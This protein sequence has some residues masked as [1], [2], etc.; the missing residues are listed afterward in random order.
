MPLTPALENPI[1]DTVRS[2]KKSKRQLYINQVIDDYWLALV[3]REA[4]LQ[5]RREVLSG[6]AK[7]GIFGDG[8]ELPQ[9]AMARAFKKGDYRAGYYRDQTLMMALGLA[10]VGSLFAQMYGDVEGDPYSSGRQM[11][12]HYATPF[13]KMNGD[14]NAQNLQYNI[15]AGISSTGGQMARA[16]GLAFASKK[17]REMNDVEGFEQF[18]NNGNEVCFCT[19]G[20]ASTSEGVFWE[21]VNAAGVEQIPLVI[22][23]WDDGFG[24]SV[25]TEKQTTK[26]SISKI[27]AGFQRNDDGNGLDIYTVNAFDYT[28]LCVTFERAAKKA[29]KKHRP[30]VVHV[31]NCTQPQGHS[32]SGSHERYKSKDRL[33]W[34][35]EYDCI[36]RMEEWMLVNN[37]ISEDQINIMRRESRA[38]VRNSKLEAWNKYQSPNDQVRTQLLSIVSDIDNSTITIDC[39]HLINSLVYPTRSELL[40][41]GRKLS[42]DLHASEKLIP[43]KLQELISKIHSDLQGSYGSYL[44][45]GGAQSPLQVPIVHPIY[46][47]KSQTINGYQVINS[48]F[49]NMLETRRDLFVFGEDVGKIGDVN[50]GLAGLQ[51]K[52][53]EHRVFDTGIREWTILGQGAGL[54]MRGLRPIAE[55]QYLDYLVYALPFLTDDVATLRY[56]S[57]G[58]Q[59]VPLI[60]RTRGHRL[61][62]IWHTG[63]PLGMMINSL[64]GIH[65]CVPRNMVEAAGM[66][67][68]LLQGKDPGIVVECLNGYRIKE[69]VPDNIGTYT[70]PLGIPDIVLQG[71]HITVVTYGSCVRYAKEAAEVLTEFGI[72]IELIDVRTLL[73]FD[74]ERIIVKSLSKTNRILFLDEDVPGGASAYMMQ[75]VLEVQ[76]GYKYLDSNPI[77][78]TSK[79]HRTPYGSDGDYYAKPQ[80]EDIVEKIYQLIFETSLYS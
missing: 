14:W 8:K 18:S 66:Y 49:D 39:I 60:V 9:I 34:E 72:S 38:H 13:N 12:G 17:Y 21:S 74:S 7:F 58:Q 19:I 27:L 57:A 64:R 47:D 59:Q 23:I 48:Y 32:T 53:G 25:S 43:E 80:V 5:G 24:I 1:L 52:Y 3:S 75:Q 46:S 37:L 51:E 77:T 69:R 40:Q 6:K 61:E 76:Q 44:H 50:Q 16:M 33:R 15:S 41:V 31:K 55:I 68:T 79:D 20:D 62:G 45:V 65:I 4:S 78:I 56:R 28:E 71:E 36:S 73:P 42:F 11:S 67:N 22:A 30:S 54:A 10:D 29:R 2:N 35:V 26:G 70:I 63:S